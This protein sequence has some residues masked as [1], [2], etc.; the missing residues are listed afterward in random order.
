MQTVVC[1]TFLSAVCGC[2]WECVRASVFEPDL[3]AVMTLSD[4]NIN[5]PHSSFE[6]AGL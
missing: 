5:R 2:V 4:L 6:T 3:D 1:S